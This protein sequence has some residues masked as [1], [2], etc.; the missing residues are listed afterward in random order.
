MKPSILTSFALLLVLTACSTIQYVPE[1]KSLSKDKTMNHSKIYVLRPSPAG[2]LFKEMV[3]DDKG[4][5]GTLGP[6]H[7]LVWDRKPGLARISTYKSDNTLRFTLEPGREY[8]FLAEP[9]N[10]KLTKKFAL[11]LSQIDEIQGKKIL[12]SCKQPTF[13]PE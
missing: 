11:K 1:P 8:Y 9:E 4:A 10:L 13:R 6:K 5:V 2:R 7:Y 12:K 3:F